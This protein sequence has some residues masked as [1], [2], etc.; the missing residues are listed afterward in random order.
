MSYIRL[1]IVQTDLEKQKK[2]HCTCG[3]V[4]N[5]GLGSVKRMSIRHQVTDNLGENVNLG[6]Y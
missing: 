4:E 3:R 5:K 2:D 1:V 6:E